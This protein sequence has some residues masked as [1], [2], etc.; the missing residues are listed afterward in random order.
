M[1]SHSVTAKPHSL[2]SPSSIH[3]QMEA[4]IAYVCF[5]AIT[6]Y[7]KLDKPIKGKYLLYSVETGKSQ[8]QQ[9]V[10]W[11]S[12]PWS[13]TKSSEMEGLHADLR[14]FVWRS[15]GNSGNTGP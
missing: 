11:A 14:N 1:V 9:V 6:K 13:H 2:G 5:V 8:D 3:C 12:S 15:L 7:Q 4:M 10:S